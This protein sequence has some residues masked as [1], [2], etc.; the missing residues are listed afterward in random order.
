M[1]LSSINYYFSL[2]GNGKF[3]FLYLETLQRISSV[4]MK[5][6][7][8]AIG[9]KPVWVADCAMLLEDTK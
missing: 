2:N 6:V 8:I 3:A 9:P 1:R 4:G 7:C 5:A